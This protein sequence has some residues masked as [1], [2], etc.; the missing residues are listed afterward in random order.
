MRNWYW[1]KKLAKR[2]KIKYS[3]KLL[4]KTRQNAGN[5]QSWMVKIFKKCQKKPKYMRSIRTT[6]PFQIRKLNKS[7]G[8]PRHHR[9]KFGEFCENWDFRKV[10][11]VKNENLKPWVWRSLEKVLETLFVYFFQFAQIWEQKRTKTWQIP[12]F[13]PFWTGIWFIVWLFRI[14]RNVKVSF[15][16]KF[17]KFVWFFTFSGEKMSILVAL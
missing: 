3:F 11:C 2:L 17:T 13:W 4:K 16:T 9:V 8:K 6:S 7:G 10:N 15:F 1:Q 12:M 5:K 14:I